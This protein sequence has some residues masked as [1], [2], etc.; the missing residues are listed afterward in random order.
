MEGG[1]WEEEGSNGGR[2]KRAME[3][4]DRKNEG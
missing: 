2:W 3:G 1:G 4:G